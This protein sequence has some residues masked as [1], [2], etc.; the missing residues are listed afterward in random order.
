MPQIKCLNNSQNGE[1]FLIQ[2]KTLLTKGNN[3]H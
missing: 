2:G 3:F 1:S